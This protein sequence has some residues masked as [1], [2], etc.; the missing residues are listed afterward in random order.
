M[1]T[2]QLQVSW[3]KCFI[4]RFLLWTISTQEVIPSIIC[5]DVTEIRSCDRVS[6]TPAYLVSRKQFRAS[7]GPLT[8]SNLLKPHGER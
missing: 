5:Y 8:P 7:G 4:L 1:Q 2:I 3:I 6:K